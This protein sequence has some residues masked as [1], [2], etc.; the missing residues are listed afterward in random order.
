MTARLPR[1]TEYVISH[2]PE[3]T[4]SPGHWYVHVRRASLES[5]QWYVQ[6]SP[7]DR[8]GDFAAQADD[9]TLRWEWGTA[10]TAPTYPLWEALDL[11][12]RLSPMDD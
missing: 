3:E 4:R 9:G 12:S 10:G 1:I 7:V 11:A 2:A 5:E 6:A 8:Y